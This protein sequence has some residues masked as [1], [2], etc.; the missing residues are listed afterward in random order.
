MFT[1]NLLF[2]AFL[3]LKLPKLFEDEEWRANDIVLDFYRD[4][5]AG[6]ESVEVDDVEKAVITGGYLLNDVD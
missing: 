6:E 4:E 2:S 3:N 5:G 1:S